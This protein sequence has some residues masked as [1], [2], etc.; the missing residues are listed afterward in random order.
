MALVPI[1]IIPPS[2]WYFKHKV[3]RREILGTIISLVGV[4]LF[5]L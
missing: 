1:F 4:A 3:T 2:I 5:F